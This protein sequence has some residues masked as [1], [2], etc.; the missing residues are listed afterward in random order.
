[1]TGA[2]LA[3]GILAGGQGTRFGG[4]DK[5]WI[6][7]AGRAQIEHVLAALRANALA[8][9]AAG[10]VGIER[11]MVSANRNLDRY[12]ALDIDVVPDRWPDC[13]GPMAGVA[14][15]VDARQASDTMLLTLP[16]DHRELP[17]DFVL[18]MLDAASSCDDCV[19]ASDGDGIQPLFALYP[20]RQAR[21]LADAFAAGERSINRWQ[22]TRSPRTCHFEPLRFGNLNSPDDLVA[23]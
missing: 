22:Q 7:R 2:R 19:V 6:E 16:V 23:P 9:D 10:V 13:P 17:R 8:L 3:V 20:P 5:G 12:R 18:R 21:A 4:A 11:V 15:L 1:M 14:S